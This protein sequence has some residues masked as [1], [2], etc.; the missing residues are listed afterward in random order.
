M[1]GPEFFPTPADIARKMVEPYGPKIFTRTILEPHA[2]K[3]DLVNALQSLAG[4][5]SQKLEVDCIEIHP[6]LQAVLRGKGC[7]L[8]S[9]DF[10]SWRPSRLY[11]LIVMNPPFSNGDEH[12]LHAWECLHG[13]DI[14]CLLNA[15]TLEN[16]HTKRRQLLKRIVDEHGTVE[17]L[18]PCFDSAERKTRTDVVLIRLTKKVADPF[19]TLFE[20]AKLSGMKMVDG[21]DA[22]VDILLPAHRDVVGNMAIQFRESLRLFKEA[23]IAMRRLRTTMSPLSRYVYLS[24]N[25]NRDYLVES[26]MAEGFAPGCN[27]F[28]TALSKEA[29]DTVVQMAGLKQLMTQ[30]VRMQFDRHITENQ[31]L[32]FTE[33]NIHHLIGILRDNTL[34]IMKEALYEVFDALTRYHEENRVHVEGW[35]TNS[36]YMAGRRFILPMV[37]RT[38]YSD[39]FSLNKY[40][41]MDDIDRVMCSLEGKKIENI[42]TINAALQSAFGGSDNTAESAFF[43]MRFF[44]KGTV[45]FR[46]KD[47][48][49]WERFN[50]EAA[51]GKGWLPPNY[52][53]TKGA[54]LKLAYG[55]E[56]PQ[57]QPRE[58]QP[59]ALFSPA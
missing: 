5:Y 10:L 26:L 18:G 46:F 17:K 12:L 41:E 38:Y 55:E 3:G 49:L 39:H 23:M 44:K 52:H 21:S 31:S 56:T 43:T 37:V 33:E 14:A 2:G 1:F 48:S 30:Q 24:G 4:R 54:L 6:E 15:A 50:C 11:D 53:Y 7:K 8:I 25:R 57:K 16:P 40:Q 35:K 51:K 59:L 28:A 58:P 45:H 47:D 36:A 29:W 34:T 22:P 19:N 42:L 32:D 9:S 27:A 13:G 20:E